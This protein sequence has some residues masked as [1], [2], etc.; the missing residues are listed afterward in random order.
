MK[1]KDTKITSDTKGEFKPL[2]EAIV[3]QDD[4]VEENPVVQT[5]EMFSHALSMAQMEGRDYL[6]VSERVFK[7]LVRNNKTDSI[8]VGNP[9][10]RVFIEGTREKILSL[11]NLSIEE[12]NRQIRGR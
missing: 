4:V 11:E 2:P 7:Y 5:P 3:P 6:D 1:Q 9:G 10:V 8:T 12:Y